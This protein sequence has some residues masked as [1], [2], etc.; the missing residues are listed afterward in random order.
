MKLHLAQNFLN[1]IFLDDAYRV[2]YKL[3]TPSGVMSGSTSISKALPADLDIPRKDFN[4][5]DG[6]QRFANVGRIDWRTLS[7]STIQILD[8]QMDTKDFFR[9]EGIYGKVFGGNHIFTGLDGK[10][11]KWSSSKGFVS[12]TSQVSFTYSTLGLLS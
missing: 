7:S 1:L 11:Y 3:N 8:Q 10:E 6:G 12:P 4:A 2:I 9:S 5:A